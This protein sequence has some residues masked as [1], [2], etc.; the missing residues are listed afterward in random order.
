MIKTITLTI[1][2]SIVASFSFSQ[3]GTDKNKLDAY[4]DKLADNNKFMGS[5][6]VS[7]NGTIIYTKAVGYIDLDSNQKANTNSKYR[8]GSITKTF[9]AVLIMKAVEENKLKLDQKLADYFP[10]IKNAEKITISQLLYHRSGIHNF[11]NDESYLSWNTTAHTAAEMVEIITRGGSDFEPDSKGEY[12]NSNFILLTYILEKTYKQ[13]YSKILQDKITKPLELK[14][15]YFG[16]KINPALNECY[17]YTFDEKWVKE[18][19]T[20]ISIPMGAGGIV[21]TPTDLVLFSDV[22]FNGKL[23]T[24]KSLEQ[25]ETFK[26][27]YGMGLFMMP[28]HDNKGFGHTGGIDGFSSVFSYFP[29]EKISIALTSNGMNYSS[30]N[31][32]IAIL[33]WAYDQPFDI[34]DFSNYITNTEQLDPYLGVYSS[35]H[36][37]IKITI[38]KKDL[39]LIAQAEGQDAFPMETAGKDQFRFDRAGIEIEFNPAEKKMTLKQGGAS[40]AFTK[41]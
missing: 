34:P 28:F 14:S 11:T 25:M 8:I 22:L 33:S 18:T 30:N 29:N 16:N 5:V 3:K 41:E 4:F 24:A 27:Q 12:S 26:D 20:D 13:P 40:F 31:I 32:G 17:S 2:L 19:E 7:K 37:P 36:L 38:S 23:L 15:T 39:V 10:G 6:A 35:K 9:T 21:S 1:V